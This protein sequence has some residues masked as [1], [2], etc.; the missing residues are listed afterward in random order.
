MLAAPQRCSPPQPSLSSS[1][2][3]LAALAPK[4]SPP[5]QAAVRTHAH[6]IH[7]QEWQGEGQ[8][9]VRGSSRLVAG[10]ARGHEYGE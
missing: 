7:T 9:Q 1:R 4:A 5:G 2:C 3:P 8:E 6:T 10:G